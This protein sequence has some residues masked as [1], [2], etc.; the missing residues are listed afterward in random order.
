MDSTEACF[1]FLVSLKSKRGPSQSSRVEPQFPVAL[2]ARLG[3]LKRVDVPAVLE[4]LR[5]G[6]VHSEIPA[7]TASSTDEN[8]FLMWPTAISPH[9]TASCVPL[10]HLSL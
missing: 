2:N 4:A 8:I 7:P 6:I 3:F 5:D 1:T 10:V 9:M